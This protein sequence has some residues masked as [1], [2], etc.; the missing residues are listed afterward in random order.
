MTELGYGHPPLPQV[1]AI[2]QRALDMST[3]KSGRPSLTAYPVDST[4]PHMRGAAHL[5]V[6]GSCMRSGAVA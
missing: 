6:P 3:L 4:G 1:R 2:I 5:S